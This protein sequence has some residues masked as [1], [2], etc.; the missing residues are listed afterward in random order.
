MS[1]SNQPREASA[2][3]ENGSKKRP[4]LRLSFLATVLVI[5]ALMR[6]L[7]WPRDPEINP[8]ELSNVDGRS[9]FCPTTYAAKAPPNTSLSQRLFW[10][11]SQYKRRHGNRKPAAYSFP[12]S[13]VQVVKLAERGGFEPP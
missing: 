9:R 8:Y 1:T 12:A 13:P 11:W 6:W 5:A 10:E 4:A 2:A 3:L 7:V